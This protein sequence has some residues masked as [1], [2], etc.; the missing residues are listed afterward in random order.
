MKRRAYPNCKLKDAH[1]FRCMLDKPHY[2]QCT[3]EKRQELLQEYTLEVLQQYKRNTIIPNEGWL[4]GIKDRTYIRTWVE[5]G[6]PT[7]LPFFI[8]NHKI[9][10]QNEEINSAGN[11]VVKITYDKKKDL[12]PL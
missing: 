9:L 2:P 4:I 3:F 7:Y 5:P 6:C 11:I 1:K 10:I 12:S 8:D